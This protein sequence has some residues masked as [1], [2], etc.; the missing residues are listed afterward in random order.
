MAFV[1]QKHQ[2][3]FFFFSF[4]L[5]INREITS[6]V[7]LKEAEPFRK[8]KGNCFKATP[9]DCRMRAVRTKQMLAAG[10][11]GNAPFRSKAEASRHNRPE[12]HVCSEGFIIGAH[13]SRGC[14]VNMTLVEGCS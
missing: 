1:H 7:E 8:G 11:L 12:N 9:L 4:K 13:K 6:R 10:W 2:R 14:G 5:Y 3:N